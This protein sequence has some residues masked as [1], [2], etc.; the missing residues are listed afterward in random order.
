MNLSWLLRS[1][2]EKAAQQKVR[3]KVIEAAKDSLAGQASAAEV[4]ADDRRCD[5]AVVCALGIEAGVLEDRLSDVVTLRG[6]GF[7]LR[8]GLLGGRRVAVVISGPG[9]TA[10]ATATAAFLQAYQ[11]QWLIS[12][13]FAGGLHEDLPRKHLLV[14]AMICDVEGRSL[15]VDLRR[16]P[17]ELL[18]L[19]PVH[20][21]TLLTVDHVVRHEE[22]KRLL[23]VAHRALAVDMESLAVAEVCRRREMP[24]LA[25]RV[26]SDAVDEELPADVD[27]LLRQTSKAGRWGAALG[28]I[29]NRPG[30]LKD[31]LKLQQAALAAS[32]RLAQYLTRLTRR[33][34]APVAQDDGQ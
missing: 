28:A 4:A 14:A 30:S 15:P 29:V 21:G 18:D 11:P 23:G 33:L 24:F 32:D 31:M 26:I 7:V 3:E 27:R 16:F 34:V 20:V 17:P 13:G 12:A 5:V 6:Q 2:L 1:M 10:A 8:R 25:V 22:E 9:P 19:E